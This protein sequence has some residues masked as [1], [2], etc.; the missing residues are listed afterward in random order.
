M[1][2]KR[3][4]ITQNIILAATLIGIIVVNIILTNHIKSKSD[5]IYQKRLISVDKLIE[6]DRDA[7]QSRLALAELI[8]LTETK[9]LTDGSSLIEDINDNKAQTE[10]RYTHFRGLMEYE[11]EP[12]KEDINLFYARFDSWST[13]TENIL[14]A[15][16]DGN[17]SRTDDLYIST[18]QAAFGEMRDGMDR[19]TEY[20]LEKAAENAAD[21]EKNQILMRTLNFILLAVGISLIMMSLL[22]TRN[23]VARPIERVSLR[24][25][26]LSAGTGD[27]TLRL[28]VSGNDEMTHLAININ[29]FI[30]KT[31]EILVG[32]KKAID[33][34]SLVKSGLVA[35]IEQNSAALEEI[36]ANMES[37][38]NQINNLDNN[39]RLNTESLEKSDNSIKNL[40]DKISDEASMVEESTAAVTEMMA[41]IENMSKTI[42]S[43]KTRTG[44]VQKLVNEGEL[45]VSESVQAVN[46][47]HGDIDSILEM[48]QLIAGIASQTNLLAMN[49]AIEAAHAGDAGKGFA[50]VADEIRKLAEN[51]GNQSKSINEILKQIINNIESASTASRFTSQTYEDV[52]KEFTILSQVF[53]EINTNSNELNTGGQQILLAMNSLQDHSLQVKEESISLKES[54]SKINASMKEIS[55]V[56]LAVNN[57]ST[58]MK[59][60]LAEIRSSM[61]EQKGLSEKLNG[62]VNHSEDFISRFKLSE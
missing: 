38:L 46:A 41:S 20:S 30:N 52:Q 27:L 13:S 34:S 22:Q 43:R 39:V 26:D 44:E 40:E 37:I 9:R 6:A 57:S 17:I 59:L 23:R 51:T 7:Y 29:S 49:A 54:S 1:T 36:T 4:L 19:L 61:V 33:D 2:I 14:E 50:V 8:W 16:F 15:V 56:S 55:E 32:L 42:Q 45:R 11:P 21:I 62:A 53:D 58:Q 3:R 28:P 60:G 35:S 47:I 31:E 25:N 12:V 10:E 48:T 18:Y 5:D 24:V